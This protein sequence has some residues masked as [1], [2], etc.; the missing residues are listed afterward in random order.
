MTLLP[1]ISERSHK[2]DSQIHLELLKNNKLNDKSWAY[3]WIQ[4]LLG[5]GHITSTYEKSKP[6]RKA[7]APCFYSDV[8][9]S[10]IS[11]FSDE[12]QKL[13]NFLQKE[14]ENDFTNIAEP[15]ALC[16][17]D[18]NCETMFGITID[19]L[20]N[21]KLECSQSVTK[22]YSKYHF[23]MVS[24]LQMIKIAWKG[25]KRTLNFLEKF[26]PESVAKYHIQVSATV[27]CGAYIQ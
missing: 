3:E 1:E 18:I 24:C 12:A 19:A 15:I 8:L 20:G 22:Q 6:R 25:T 13:V 26:L 27:P 16:A 9:R 4:P 21:K 23:H 17:V 14:S 10:F 7:L 11:V 5:K 2:S